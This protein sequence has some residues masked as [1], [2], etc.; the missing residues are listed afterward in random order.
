MS[1]EKKLSGNIYNNKKQNIFTKPIKT[2]FNWPVEKISKDIVSSL[3]IISH[4]CCIGLSCLCYVPWSE[5]VLPRSG[6]DSVWRMV[7]I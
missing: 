7:T 5:S 2:I 6:P 3:L 4:L 1:K